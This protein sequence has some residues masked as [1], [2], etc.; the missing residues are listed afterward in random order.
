MNKMIFAL[1]TMAYNMN[2][3]ASS[4]AAKNMAQA[5]SMMRQRLA[6]NQEVPLE[7]VEQVEEADVNEN[8][9]EQDNA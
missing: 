8:Q 6:H 9:E 1:G 5:L 7:D 2:Q 3:M 4:D